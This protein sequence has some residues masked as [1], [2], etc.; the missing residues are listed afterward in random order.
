MLTTSDCTV[1][2][3]SSSSCCETALSPNHTNIMFYMYTHSLHPSPITRRDM[4]DSDS[5]I[6]AASPS[7]ESEHHILYRDSN[8]SLESRLATSASAHVDGKV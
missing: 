8:A 4:K 2:T 5:S 3:A 7:L 6:E 1:L